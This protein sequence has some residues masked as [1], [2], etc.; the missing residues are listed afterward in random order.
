MGATIDAEAHA[1]TV[2]RGRFPLAP[3]TL[4]CNHIPDAAM[5]L[6]ALALF[7]DGHDRG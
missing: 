5:T 1:L 2:R 7:A 4:D 6:A 3:I